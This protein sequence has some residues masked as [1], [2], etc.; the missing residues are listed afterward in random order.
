MA[1]K[2]TW[3]REQTPFFSD[4]LHARAIFSTIFVNKQAYTK[5]NYP[6]ATGDFSRAKITQH[7]LEVGSRGP[8][9]AECR[10]LKHRADKT[11]TK[12]ST[13]PAAASVL[14][15]P[16]A[17]LNQWLSEICTF[18]AETFICILLQNNHN[19]AAYWKIRH[20]SAQIWQLECSQVGMVEEHSVL[21]T[22]E[23]ASECKVQLK[24]PRS[25]H[26]QLCSIFLLKFCFAESH[27]CLPQLREHH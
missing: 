16:G 21:V 25:L 23:A 3:N 2:G 11:P 22:S 15:T 19:A 14:H 12:C 27:P 1:E 8:A 18:G 9:K 4:F 26:Q 7:L 6:K 20:S 24:S 17:A 10:A 5:K 13:E